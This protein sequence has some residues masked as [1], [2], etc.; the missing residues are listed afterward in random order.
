MVELLWHTFP[1]PR[2]LLL[3]ARDEKLRC[4]QRQLEVS[5]ISPASCSLWGWVRAASWRNQSSLIAQGSVVREAAQ[6]SPALHPPLQ[7]HFCLHPH[8]CRGTSLWHCGSAS[9]CR[10]SGRKRG[11][12][13]T[14]GTLNTITSR[15]PFPMGCFVQNELQV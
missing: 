1:S 11:C 2:T 10:S 12:C 15:T 9:M 8:H 5:K 3:A 7:P 13:N 4:A 14:G 6:P